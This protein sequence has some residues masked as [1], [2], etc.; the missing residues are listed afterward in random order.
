M[1]NDGALT[2]NRLLTIWDLEKGVR[3]YYI[4]KEKRLLRKCF[5]TLYID[6][7]S[8]QILKQSQEQ[9]SYLYTSHNMITSENTL[10]GE[11]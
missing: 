8:F 5:T 7:S 4:D 9:L 1:D 2:V 10:E 11:L 3:R 6:K